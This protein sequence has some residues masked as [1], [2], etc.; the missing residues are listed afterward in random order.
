MK[1]RILLRGSAISL[2]VIATPAL[3][4]TITPATGTNPDQPSTAPK[5]AQSAPPQVADDT[6]ASADGKAI[7]VTATRSAKAIDKIP[8]AVS[9]ISEKEITQQNLIADDPSAALAA[10]IPGFSPSR[11]KLSSKG[12]SIRGRSALI[13][14]DGIPQ[15]N[16]LR[17]GGR[18]GYFIDSAVVK[19]IE[20]VSGASAIYGLG[21]TGGIVN[22]ITRDAPEGTHQQIDLRAATGFN[23]GDNL[24]WKAGYLVTHK[25]D[26]LDVVA[27]AGYDKRGMQYDAHGRILGMTPSVGDSMDSHALNLF[28]KVGKDFDG[29]RLQFT[30]N[31][32]RLFGEGNFVQVDGNALQFIPTGATRGQYT[33]GIPPYNKMLSTNLTYSNSHFLSGNLNLQLFTHASDVLFGGDT[34]TAFQDPAIAPVGKLFD[35]GLVVD[36]KKGG[37]ITYVHP[38]AFFEGVEITLGLDQIFDTTHNDLVITN[39]VWLPPLKYHST[40]PFAQIEFDRGPITV[41]GGLRYETGG[42]RVDDYTTIAYYGKTTNGF[43]GVPVK[44]GSRTFSHIVKNIGGVWRFAP[45]FSA[46]ASYSEGF[47]LPDVGILLRSVTK[48]NQSVNSLISLEPIITSAKEVGVNYRSHWGS[49]GVSAYESYSALGSTLRVGPDGLGQVVRVPT[50]VRGI[51]ASGEL[52]PTAGLSLYATYALTDGKTAEDVGKPID[53][54]LGGRTQGPDKVTGAIDWTVRP[55][56]NARLQA[57]HY[58][59]RDINQGRGPLVNGFYQLEEHFKGYTEADLTTS[60]KTKLGT[61]GVSIENLFNKYYITY[62]SQIIRTNASDANKQYVQGRG[63]TYALSYVGNF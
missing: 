26:L 63:R 18:E 13:L 22:Y 45:K 59:D 9:V 37:K 17:D 38:D 36:R 8:G 28:L 42:I 49:F 48:L 16:P 54:S 23:R 5:G 30:V 19:R 51:E 11:Q 15:G 43:K 46:F 50:R 56:I 41:R 33:Q 62:Y 29:Q 3:A 31:R 53:L 47:G 7:V 6:A 25:S 40:A 39:R 60:F 57:V 12:E 10:T 24:D 52:H 4:Q 44:G 55:G 32:F 27:Y 2:A 34:A 61:F 35:E 21:A 58:F 14:L 1:H 20:V